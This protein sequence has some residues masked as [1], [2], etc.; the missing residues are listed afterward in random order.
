MFKAFKGP[1]VFAVAISLAL[2][3][4]FLVSS[5]DSLSFSLVGVIV[6]FFAMPLL[7]KWH[8]AI[9]IIFWNTAFNAFFLPGEPDI[10]LVAAAFSLGVAVLN[11]V[12]FQTKFIRVPEMTRPLIF[13]SIVV[14]LTALYRGGISLRV[15]G[16]SSQGGKYYVYIL[17]SVVGYFA[18]T[19][20]RI[21][22]LKR[23]KMTYIFFLSGVTFV[24]GNVVYVLGPSFYMLYYLVQSAVASGQ[25]AADAGSTD[26][27]RIQGLAQPCVAIISCLLAYYG[28]RGLFNWSKPWRVLFLILPMA[29]SV[30]AGFRSISVFILLILG[31]QFYLEGLFRTRLFPLIAAALLL[32]I[33]PVWLLADKLPP[34]AQR[35]VSFLPLKVAPGVRED[36]RSSTEWRHQM[37]ALIW[38]EVPKYIIMG[39]GYTIDPTDLFLVNEGIRMGIIGSY[40]GA[41]MAS[42]FHNGPLS[43]LIPFGALGVMAFVWVLGAGAW[44]LSKNFRY[45]EPRLL[46]VNTLLLSYYLAYTTLFLFL[47]GSLNGQLYI[48]LGLVGM[49][50]S[51]NGGVRKPKVVRPRPVMLSVVGA[52]EPS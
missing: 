25:A 26:L 31:F 20:R 52:F 27:E 6:L 44:V 30:F 32:A 7:L 43:V 10:W 16:G 8:H 14:S 51:L 50:V 22:I 37:W 9:L 23:E 29:M 18:L 42:D 39:K 28:L 15:M 48:F 40:E 1:V 41:L 5:P 21:P 4:G 49:S 24:L 34:V 38:K 3:L 45:S 36:A 33:V 35:A 46:K 17:G 2:T 12:M 47:F 19:A 13:L 11:H